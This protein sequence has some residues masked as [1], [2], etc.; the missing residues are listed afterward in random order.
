MLLKFFSGAL[1]WLLLLL[2]VLS[3]QPKW[4]NN[5]I[6][7]AR[8]FHFDKKSPAIILHHSAL[9]TI[10]K[11]G[12]AESI[13]RY[14]V[15]ILTDVGTDDARIR[16]PVSPFQKVKN[17]KGWL[18][19]SSGGI[20]KLSKKNIIQFSASSAAGYYDDDHLIAAGFPEASTGDVV[21]FEYK[22]QEKGWATLFQQFVFQVQI[23]VLFTELRLKLPEGWELRQHLRNGQPVTFKKTAGGYIWTARELSYRP[24]E[25]LAPSWSALARRLQIS[26]FSPMTD[27][28]IHFADWPAVSGWLSG[29]HNDK[30]RVT[31]AVGA[32]VQQVTENVSS[33]QDKLAAVGAFAQEDIRYVAVELGKN[34]WVPR[35]APETLRNRYGDCKD[36]TILMRAMMQFMGISSASV[37]VNTSYPVS[38]GLSTPFQFNH[39]I[40]AIP[41]E[42][43]NLSES[44]QNAIAGDWFFFDPTDSDTKIGNLP[45]YLQGREVMIGAGPDTTLLRL[46]NPKPE[47]YAQRY[48][49]R[50]SINADRSFS[51]DISIA[52]TGANGFQWQRYFRLTPEKEQIEHLKDRLSRKIPELTIDNYRVVQ[53]GD[54]AWTHFTIG[55]QNYLQKT[56]SLIIFKPQILP[57]P[58][59]PLLPAG[60]RHH[61]IWLGGSEFQQ[62]EISWEFPSDWVANQSI[63]AAIPATDY[64]FE[65]AELKS[66]IKWNENMLNITSKYR[67]FGVLIPASDYA[68]ARE[69]SQVVNDWEDAA[70]IISLR[71][72]N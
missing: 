52:R 61:P 13:Y 39:C 15:K 7:E 64:Q 5:A 17:L 67:Q 30:V 32:A 58:A 72:G 54:T 16:I 19:K 20:E 10:N 22:Y 56:A 63:E 3:A 26:T 18:I 2:P 46:P 43:L 36:K 34:R 21:A 47:D 38:R 25:L 49:L 28:E 51:A 62:S 24:D 69:F 4:V 68:T 66:V 41:V 59:I 29:I 6:T 57:G 8:N 55:S 70:I 14:A 53:N 45:R 1:L 27:N 9:M 35:S 12:D 33:I 44:W 60:E 71:E 37:L 65:A 23:P 40:V 50:G 48:V 42:G 31:V 11:K